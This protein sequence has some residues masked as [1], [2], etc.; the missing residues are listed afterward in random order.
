M[1]ALGEKRWAQLGLT[2]APGREGLF[3]CL[4][5]NFICCVCVCVCVR[6]TVHK[7]RGSEDNLQEW[8]FSLHQ[9]GPGD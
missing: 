1:A 6:A 3:L 8:L 9:V 5:V 4:E 2:G 7:W